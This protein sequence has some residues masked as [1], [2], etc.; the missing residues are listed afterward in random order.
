MRLH[1]FRHYSVILSC[2]FID[3]HITQCPRNIAKTY[4]KARQCRE[5]SAIA[6]QN[7]FRWCPMQLLYISVIH[8]VHYRIRNIVCDSL[9]QSEQICRQRSRV[10]IITEINDLDGYYA[11]TLLC[12]CCLE[13]TGHH[14]S[15]SE[16]RSILS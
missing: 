4:K 11:Y 8:C 14:T 16:D 1:V 7:A 9:D 10:S 13:P 15:L 3:F 5:T 6:M 2:S 12:T